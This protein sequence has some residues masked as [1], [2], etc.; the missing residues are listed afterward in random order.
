MTE[1]RIYNVLFLCTG[2]SG[3]G[4]LRVRDV[5]RRSW[6]GLGKIVP[7]DLLLAIAPKD[8]LAISIELAFVL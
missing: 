3:Y 6:A 8:V 5:S 2:N 7:L 4:S 1:A